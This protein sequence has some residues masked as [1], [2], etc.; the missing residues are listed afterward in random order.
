MKTTLKTR[1]RLGI[2]VCL[3]CALFATFT[4]WRQ[5]TQLESRTA[6]VQ[7]QTEPLLKRVAAFSEFAA[8]L[9]ETIDRIDT[10][11]T[12]LQLESAV[13]SATALVTRSVTEFAWLQPGTRDMAQ[14]FQM[15]LVDLSTVRAAEIQLAAQFKDTGA[16]VAAQLDVALEQIKTFRQSV[17]DT[18]PVRQ[19][20]DAVS[21]AEVDQLFALAEL[22]ASLVQLALLSSGFAEAPI[23]QARG[24]DTEIRAHFADLTAAIDHL[25]ASPTKTQLRVTLGG[26]DQALFAPGGIFDLVRQ[27]D[28]LSQARGAAAGV[29]LPLGIAFAEEVDKAHALITQE[30]QAATRNTRATTQHILIVTLSSNLLLVGMSLLLLFLVFERLVISRVSAL[31]GHVEAMNA[32]TLD[33]PV[34]QH[35]ADEITLL[36]GAVESARLTS[37]D[38]KQSNEELQQFAYIAAH[39]LRSPLRA[40]SNLVDWTLEDHGDTLP[41]E[42]RTNLDLIDGRVQ[43]LSNHLSALLEYARA[44]HS[45]AEFDTLDMYDT[46]HAILADHDPDR[47]FVLTVSGVPQRFECFVLPVKTILLNLI[48]NALKHHDRDTGR[49][50][51]SLETR[52]TDLI[53]SVKD[54]G[55]GVPREYQEKVFEL[56][57]T[58]RTR[59]HVEGSGL[60]LALVQKLAQSMGGHV[61][62][63][64]NPV[65]QRG[66][67]FSIHLPE[68]S[69]RYAKRN[70]VREAAE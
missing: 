39:D 69:W 49:V 14:D 6:L 59:D 52:G 15:A 9:P 1:L 19:P 37:L 32:G 23:A 45:E 8:L 68:T 33:V 44:G 47:R 42:V 16:T 70:V 25:P 36:E 40:V 3:S 57:Q 13:D 38:L 58:I 53:I 26:L 56:F 4:E 24:K 12:G 48:S 55:P 2:L 21:S 66:T 51:I 46:A 60:G 43:R 27:H 18:A 63:T 30:F 17:Q 64:S 41:R 34:T 5:L 62:L 10:A 11:Q 61:T 28:D 31:A 50:D 22:D 35:G 7:S 67:C 20:G 29:L 65:A 54:D